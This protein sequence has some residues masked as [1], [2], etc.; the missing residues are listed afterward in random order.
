MFNTC[1]AKRYSS[2]SYEVGRRLSTENLKESSKGAKFFG[3]VPLD[4]YEDA[5]DA[6]EGS[7]AVRL[8]GPSH[9]DI[10]KY[11]IFTGY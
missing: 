3:L 7:V 11:F 1:K 9:Y 2:I 8:P 6:P 10:R 4:G 5:L